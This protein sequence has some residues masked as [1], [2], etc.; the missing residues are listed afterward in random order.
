MSLWIPIFGYIFLDQKSTFAQG[1]CVICSFIGGILVVDPSL[2]GLAGENYV[3]IIPE[4]TF[5]GARFE[6]PNM[7]LY[8]GGFL[9]LL[10]GLLFGLK[11]VLTIKGAGDIHG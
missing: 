7:N 2:L 10:A 1:I 8:F 3:E 11:R 5:S 9:G 6:D 4:K